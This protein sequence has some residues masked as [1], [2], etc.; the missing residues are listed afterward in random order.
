MAK[1]PPVFLSIF[2]LFSARCAP[3]PQCW[4]TLFYV[5]EPLDSVYSI[6]SIESIDSVESIGS[7]ESIGYI[8]SIVS[9]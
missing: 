3:W 5:F 9:M 8:D 2:C 4:Q 1:V 7:I 6:D